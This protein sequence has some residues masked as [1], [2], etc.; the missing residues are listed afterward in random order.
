[1]AAKSRTEQAYEAL[2]SEVLDGRFAPDSKLKI[3]SLCDLL[4]VSPGAVREALSRLTSDG[5]VV[6]EPQRGF[7]VA[8]VSAEDLIDL[9]SV[10]IAIETRCLRRAIQV[11]NLAW[12]GRIKDAWHQ[13]EKT[14]VRS[15]ARPD[16][17]NPDWTKLHTAFHDSLI[18]ACDSRWGLKL[19]DQMYI[20]AERYRRMLLPF[21]KV[22][23]EPDAEHEAI[24][25]AVLARDT[26]RACKLLAD[27]LQKTADILLAS[28]APFKD[29]PKGAAMRQGSTKTLQA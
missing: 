10:R 17:M 6:A 26:D 12:E 21:T 14:P 15:S 11:G 22:P 18:A 8:P 27:H 7:T 2:K 3:D 5:L 19:R 16:T 9:T 28:D 24:V 25:Q 4:G 1:M 23:R 20:Q 29:V 13:L